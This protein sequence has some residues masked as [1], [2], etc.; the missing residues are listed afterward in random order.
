MCQESVAGQTGQTNQL[1]RVSSL[2]AQ[3]SP[4][5]T[6]KKAKQVKHKTS[7]TQHTHTHTH[8]MRGRSTR[9][10]GANQYRSIS[11][12]QAD[13]QASEAARS[14]AKRLGYLHALATSQVRRQSNG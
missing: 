14:N 6:P 2:E 11:D 7:N 3:A 4:R 5:V 12:S 9:K 10:S 1:L 13:S 8:I